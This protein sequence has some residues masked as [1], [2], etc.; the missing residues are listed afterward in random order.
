MSDFLPAKYGGIC[1]APG[2]NGF[3]NI[4]SDSIILDLAPIRLYTTF[5]PKT[6]CSVL[7]NSVLSIQNKEI[8]S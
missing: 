2:R 8:I 4:F 1:P 5:R 3:D 6:K 7:H